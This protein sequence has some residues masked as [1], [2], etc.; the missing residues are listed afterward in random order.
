MAKLKPLIEYQKVDIELLRALKELKE[1]PDHEK[2]DRARTDFASAKQDITT[3][4][5]AASAILAFYET[6]KEG[7]AE[8]VAEA[9]KLEKELEK[10]ADDDEAVRR[11]IVAKMEATRN[12]LTSL[13][14]KMQDKQSKSEKIIKNYKDAQERGKK[15]KDIFTRTKEGM[16][17]FTKQKEPKI[18][19]LKA[20]LIELKKDVEPALFAKYGSLT[21]EGKIPA[22]AEA[23]S[24][25]GG[26]TYTCRGCGISI[27]QAS[28]S[29]LLEAGFCNCDSCKRMMYDSSKIN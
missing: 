5:E 9:E 17:A 21:S 24:A 4:E 12:R 29:K 19:A 14:R 26:K 11:D 16:E 20:K 28:R 1:H 13:E 7:H 23:S 10:A 3:A 2:L 27:A 15:L 6:A 25:D 22:L 8:L 18:V